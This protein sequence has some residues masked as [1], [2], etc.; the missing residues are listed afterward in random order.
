VD[1]FHGLAVLALA[2]FLAGAIGKV[3]FWLSGSLGEG[4][5]DD[6]QTTALALLRQ[7][8][9]IVLQP[10][11]LRAL[12]WNGLVLRQVWKESPFRWLIHVT[13]AWSFVGLFA[14]GSLGNMA[15]DLGAPLEK[16]DAWF[17]AFNDSMGLALLAGLALAFGRR[18]VSP[19]PYT[20]TL[21]E[22]ATVL[23]ILAVLGI[24]G[25]LV[26]A[27]RH[28]DEGTSA[29]VGGYAFLGYPLSQAVE[30]LDWDWAVVYDWLWWTHS[31]LALGLVA[32]LPYSKLS[33][34]FSSPLT[35]AL[36]AGDAETPAPARHAVEGEARA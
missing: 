9:N 6:R 10:R 7:G 28:L 19:K 4:D 36:D 8:L 23:V 17:A 35:V 14:I 15:S 2:I 18:Y 13:V 29:S 21:F 24:G 25:F 31:L 20:R 27:G 33:H 26:E 11:A 1:V 16:D 5:P 12:F 30:P 32:Y 22:D 3:R 34:M